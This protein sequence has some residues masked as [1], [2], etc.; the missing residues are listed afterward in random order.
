MTSEMFSPRGDYT[1][2]ATSST[3]SR[4]LEHV[5]RAFDRMVESSRRRLNIRALRAKRETK[6]VEEDVLK[7]SGTALAK[8]TSAM[9]NLVQTRAFQYFYMACI[10]DVALMSFLA[11]V[12]PSEFRGED[13]I[14]YN[15]L[16]LTWCFVA[17]CAMKIMSSGLTVD[18]DDGSTKLV[19]FRPRYYFMSRMN[20][21]DFFL[22]AL[23]VNVRYNK[24]T[25]SKHAVHSF[26]LVR[27]IL[28]F[29]R[30]P[31]I[32]H[33]LQ[34]IYRGVANMFWI[35]VLTG[36]V[37]YVY[38]VM[39]VMLFKDNDP[40]HFQD[41]GYGLQTVIQ[42]TTADTD[43]LTIIYINYYGCSEYG[44]DSAADEGWCTDSKARPFFS[45][46]YIVSLLFIL[47][48]IMI[49][50]FIG[51]ISQEMEETVVSTRAE[52]RLQC[53]MQ[54]ALR[55]KDL[56]SDA[57][58]IPS[59]LY[60]AEYESL[61]KHLQLLSGFAVDEP[62]EDDNARVKAMHKWR[63]MQLQLQHL[64][65][66][67]EF[68]FGIGAIIVTAG[69]ISGFTAS[70][71]EETVWANALEKT[72]LT[73]Y[74]IEL[75]LKFF[76]KLDKH[77]SFYTGHD[78]WWHV[79]DTFIV[80][81][82]LIPN[83]LTPAAPAMRLLRL[84]LLFR[85][86]RVVKPL[87]I[88]LL[89]L[90]GSMGALLY[91]VFLMFLLFFA[92]G[93]AGV[94][95]FAKN[96]PFNFGSLGRAMLTLLKLAILDDWMSLYDINANGCDVNEYGEYDNGVYYA[97]VIDSAYD[98]TDTSVVSNPCI[99]PAKA[100]VAALFFFSSFIIVGAMV[101]ISALIGIVITSVQNAKE[102][103]T[104]RVRINERTRKIARHFELSRFDINA[105]HKVYDLIAGDCEDNFTA[106]I[107]LDRMRA[108][109]IRAS[110]IFVR[111]V[112]A[113]AASVD[114]DIP[115]DRANFLLMIALVK[116]AKILALSGSATDALSNSVADDRCEKQNFE[117][118][119]EQIEDIEHENVAAVSDA[120]PSAVQ[121]AAAAIN[122]RRRAA[123]RFGR[124]RADDPSHP[125]QFTHS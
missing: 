119:I 120:A 106:D 86:V 47:A 108:V 22:T 54:L 57:D 17:E 18:Q 110:E 80:V 65:N 94:G 6:V 109:N 45:V 7:H 62:D 85:F 39:G 10:F 35:L 64:V 29:R 53:K 101:L 56:W 84:L 100:K 116:R 9:H 74:G 93:V 36:M 24:S 68:E 69:V 34:S 1:D 90:A 40:R 77:V 125:K 28:V 25:V 91:V 38:T 20:C 41:L 23:D 52:R 113:V 78:R 8:A 11:T 46:A 92:Y 5:E 3:T 43:W 58:K 98:G 118:I 66:S 124:A 111:R 21:I 48:H 117:D 103:I 50:L 123:F 99:K 4:H 26:R 95:L 32:N 81:I 75:L 19:L 67:Q 55:T 33:L 16:V 60:G 122:A 49:N 51:V 87:Q 15:F 37:I 82:G 63:K 96:D 61:T 88:V 121:A 104:I 31:D 12:K 71:S 107:L 105:A 73:C 27:M 102:S 112:F 89:S 30:V 115:F 44:Y 83:D 2:E 97:S 72:F 13:F 42:L 59:K 76:A 70:F 14:Y 114:D 79:Y